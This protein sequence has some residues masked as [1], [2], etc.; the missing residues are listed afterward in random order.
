MATTTA[1][2]IGTRTTWNIDPA[3]TQVAFSAKHMMVATVRGQFNNVA[4]TVIA[5][6]SNHANSS[7][8]VDIDATSIDT[9]NEQRDTHLRSADF[10]DAENFPQITF[11]SRGIDVLAEDHL[12]VHGDLTIR[13][14]THPVTLEATVNG[15]GKSPYGTEVAGVSLEGSLSRKDFGLN[16]NVALETG[17]VLVGD[18]VKIDIEVELVK[19]S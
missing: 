16:W 18:K 6:D 14:V 7:I 2:E 19:Q 3:H 13:G 1:T 12:N 4:G 8:E 10:L 11:R 9:R 15:R 5:D 17:G